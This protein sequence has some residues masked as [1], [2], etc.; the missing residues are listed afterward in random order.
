M[1]SE[2]EPTTQ[3]NTIVKQIEKNYKTQLFIAAIQ[4]MK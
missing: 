3:K 4:E 1:P 2:G